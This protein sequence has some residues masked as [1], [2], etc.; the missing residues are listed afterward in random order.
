[1]KKKSWPGK[2]R[3]E[4]KE[5][6]RNYPVQVVLDKAEQAVKKGLAISNIKF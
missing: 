5:G 3:Q 2:K 1:M 6:K 4:S